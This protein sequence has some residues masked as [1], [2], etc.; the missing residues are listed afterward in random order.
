MGNL[1]PGTYAEK[2]CAH[3]PCCPGARMRVKFTAGWLGLTGLSRPSVQAAPRLGQDQ[4]LVSL[5]ALSISSGGCL[6]A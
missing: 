3:I 6:G 5:V 2:D 1:C 4:G